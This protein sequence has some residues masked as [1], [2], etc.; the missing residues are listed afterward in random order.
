MVKKI[1]SLYIINR[2][3]LLME[4]HCAVH[5]VP[6]GSVYI[7]MTLFIKQRPISTHF[8]VDHRTVLLAGMANQQQ[9]E[10]KC[11]LSSLNGTQSVFECLRQGPK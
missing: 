1:N 3:V 8:P 11:S 4:T 9:Y 7:M 10:Q 6:N 5:E 2:Q